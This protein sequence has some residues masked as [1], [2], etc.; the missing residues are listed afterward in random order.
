MFRTNT[1]SLMNEFIPAGK[2]CIIES[3]SE[4]LQRLPRSFRWCIIPRTSWC[5][6]ACNTGDT[7]AVV[8]TYFLGWKKERKLQYCSRSNSAKGVPSIDTGYAYA[9]SCHQ[10]DNILTFFF[11]H[12]MFRRGAIIFTPPVLILLVY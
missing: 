11:M 7:Y 4:L 3:G 1:Y 5:V 8:S 10:N 2:V 12:I 6:H 9:L